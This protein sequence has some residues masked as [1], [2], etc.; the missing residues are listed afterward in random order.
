MPECLKLTKDN[1]DKLPFMPKSCAYRRLFD[2]DYED[3]PT[4]SLKN[5]VVSELNIAAEEIENYIVDWDDL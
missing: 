4:P 5:R 1:V 3:K 2:A